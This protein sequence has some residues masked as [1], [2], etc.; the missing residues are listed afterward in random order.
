MIE[1]DE[2]LLKLASVFLTLGEVKLQ[3]MVII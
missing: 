1:L 2:L 3:D